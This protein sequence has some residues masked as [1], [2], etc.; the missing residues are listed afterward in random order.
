VLCGVVLCGVVLCGVVT[1][2][3]AMLGVVLALLALL[4]VCVLRTG[5]RSPALVHAYAHGLFECRYTSSAIIFI[6][7]S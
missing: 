3:L 5:S 4:A 1:V 6:G 2:A 7:A